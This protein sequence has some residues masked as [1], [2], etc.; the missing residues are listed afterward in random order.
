ML[1]RLLL[2]SL[3]LFMANLSLV[4]LVPTQTILLPPHVLNNSGMSCLGLEFAA[5]PYLST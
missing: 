5:L 2:S 4:A 3:K 1:L